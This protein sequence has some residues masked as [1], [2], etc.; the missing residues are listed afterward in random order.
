MLTKSQL[1]PLFD[2][3][4]DLNDSS[5]AD[6]CEAPYVV[7]DGSVLEKVV[8]EARRLN[9][10]EEKTPQQQ[11]EELRDAGLTFSEC[12]SV[13]GSNETDPYVLSALDR[14]SDGDLL[15][16]APTVVSQSEEGAYVQAWMWVGFSVL[17][18]D[19]QDSAEKAGYKVH[20]GQS[21]AGDLEGRYWWTLSTNGRVDIESSTEVFDEEE[22]AWL[23]AIFNF[24]EK[25]KAAAYEKEK[26][27][28]A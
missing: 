23:D 21:D 8:A 2:L 7:L 9:Q 26:S 15:V 12:T 28:E 5:A 25:K 27:Q 18:R 19:H 11:L 24:F 20:C 3:I 16:E 6:G 13:F 10:V 14:T 22:A 4:S 17:L 1:K